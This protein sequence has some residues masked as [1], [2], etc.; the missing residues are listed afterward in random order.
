M[1][2]KKRRL[3]DANV[4]RLAP[5]AREY[6]IWDTRYAGLGVRVRPSGHRSFV[7]LRKGEDGARRI[8]IGPAAL[9]G[10]EEARRKCLAIESGERPLS[11]ERHAAVTFADFVSGPGRACIDRC[12]PSTQKAV[13]WLLRARL[14]PAFGSIPLNRITHADVT[15]WFDEYS[16]TAPGGAN[17]ASGRDFSEYS[18]TLWFAGTS[19]RIRHAASSGTPVQ[20]L[21]A[22]CRAGRSAGFIARWTGTPP[23]GRRSRIKRTSSAFCC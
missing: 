6:T 10:V 20:S 13:R 22:S 16:Q 15:R 1:A 9:T 3:T 4:A 5:A 11:A 7:Y 18:T 23:C 19:T 14:L 2:A 8:T 17:H 12:K 21:L